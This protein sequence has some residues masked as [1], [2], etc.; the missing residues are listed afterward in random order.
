[1]A[2]LHIIIPIRRDRAHDA[3][4]NAERATRKMFNFLFSRRPSNCANLMARRPITMFHH[5]PRG[6]DMITSCFITQ[7][8]VLLDII[9]LNN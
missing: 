7:I 2:D 8:R 5:Y 6:K 9:V 3:V 1:M 4:F